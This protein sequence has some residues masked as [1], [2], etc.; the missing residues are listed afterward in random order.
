MNPFGR[1]KQV[2]N[3]SGD[4]PYVVDIIRSELDSVCE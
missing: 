4:I 3:L 2:S 1:E